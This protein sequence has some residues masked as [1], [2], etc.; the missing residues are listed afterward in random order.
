M[1]PYCTLFLLS[2]PSLSFFGAMSLTHPWVHTESLCSLVQLFLGSGCRF[3]SQAI[4]NSDI[5]NLVLFVHFFGFI[6]QLLFIIIMCYVY[7]HDVCVLGGCTCHGARVE[8]GG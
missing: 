7:V 8:I 3:R 2:A 4:P 1:L 6:S 5:Q